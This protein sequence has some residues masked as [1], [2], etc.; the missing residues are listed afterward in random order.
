MT[1]KCLSCGLYIES[2]DREGKTPLMVVAS[3]GQN[4]AVK[5]LL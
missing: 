3:S 1:E 4:E 2:K 5:F